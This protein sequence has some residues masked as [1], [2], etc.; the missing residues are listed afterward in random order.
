MIILV[1]HHRQPTKI[2][3]IQLDL[4]MEVEDKVALKGLCKAAAQTLLGNEFLLMK[5]GPV[6]MVVALRHSP[7]E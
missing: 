6:A 3:G 7:A 5:L 2:Y 1:V 4:T